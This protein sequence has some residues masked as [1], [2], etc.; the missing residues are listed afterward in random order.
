[1]SLTPVR[2]YSAVS[3]SLTPVKYAKTEKA[4]L[5]GVNDT[6]E[7]FHTGVNDAGNVCFAGVVDT[8]EAPK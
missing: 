1:V 7:K 2:N 3:L 5:T 4:F 8:G 6:G